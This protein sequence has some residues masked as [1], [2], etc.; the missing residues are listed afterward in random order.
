MNSATPRVILRLCLLI[1]G[2]CLLSA[3]AGA[4]VAAMQRPPLWFLLMFEVAV[5]FACFF[6][7]LTGLGRLREGPALSMLIASG[8]LI[9]G[10]MLGEPA[11]PLRMLGRTGSPVTVHGVAILPFAFARLLCGVA[12]GALAALTILRRRPGLSFGYLLRAAALGAPVALAL[13]AMVVPAIR[14]KVSGL[15]PLAGFFAAVLGFFV[16]GGFFCASAHCLIRAFEVGQVDR[17]DAGRPAG[18]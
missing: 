13:G 16:L 17:I 14:A 9:V 11:L 8:A 18:S 15:P 5:A 4:A 1:S 12:M 2:V 10:A 6:A 7:V 3:I